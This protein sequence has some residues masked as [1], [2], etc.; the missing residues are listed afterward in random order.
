MKQPKIRFKRWRQSF[1]FSLSLLL[2]YPYSFSQGES[3][4]DRQQ[5]SFRLNLLQ[6]TVLEHNGQKPPY[7]WSG[8]YLRNAFSQGIEFASFQLDSS[9]CGVGVAGTQSFE[10]KIKAFYFY[11]PE[12]QL[13]EVLFKQARPGPVYEN[14]SRKR[15]TYT[16]GRRSKYLY[17]IWNTATNSWQDD[18]EE[19]SSFNSDGIQQSFVIR[20]SEMGQ[21]QNVFRERRIIDQDGNVSEVLSAKWE[22]NAWQDT[23]RKE[24]RYNERGFFTILFEERWNGSSWDTLSRESAIYG[25]NGMTWEGYRYE[26]KT[27]N[28]FENVLRESYGYNFRGYYSEMTLE[29]WDA[30]SNSWRGET[31]ESYEYNR[32]GIWTGWKRQD[33]MG[34][35]YEDSY[36]QRFQT[37]NNNRLDIRQIWDASSNSWISEAR[38]LA[39]YDS[40]FNLTEEVG[41]QVWDGTGWVNGETSRRCLHFWS[42]ES[43]TSIRPQLP[44]MSCEL[45][46]PYRSYSP[47]RCDAMQTGKSYNVRLSD[48]QGRLVL[49]QSI[50]GANSFSIDKKIPQGIYNLN[51]YQ[52]QQILFSKKLLIRE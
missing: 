40:D 48:M 10:T 30:Q 12:G 4:A 42:E 34:S 8:V 14:F 20:E 18:Y 6:N 5:A 41:I 38:T 26:Q 2:M 28:G 22:N 17:Q 9:Y 35:A 19:T 39:R 45:S 11:N 7:F 51:I 24:I 27:P 21:W 3:L 23:A 15:Y 29:L 37:D 13:S 32:M 33:W 49:D 50:S 25:S 52:N 16:E 31:R 36:R 1:L 46:N 47:I 43:L 44:Q